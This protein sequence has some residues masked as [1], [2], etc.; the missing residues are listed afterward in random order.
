M[1]D[2]NA[3]MTFLLEGS[4]LY[5]G[6][7]DQSSS[8]VIKRYLA[9]RIIVNAMSFEDLVGKRLDTKMR[10]IR[11]VILA[12]KQESDFFEGHKAADHI[13]NQTITSLMNFMEAQIS[14]IDA[15]YLLAENIDETSKGMLATL[16]PQ[17]F[18]LYQKDFLA[19]FRIINNYLCFT[20]QS[21]HEV[22]KNDLAG[23]FYRYHSSKSL[24]DLSEYLFNNAKTEDNLNGLYR[25]TKLDMLMHAQNMADCIIKDNRNNHSID[26]LLEVMTNEKIGD[27]SP[28]ASLASDQNFQILYQKVRN[29]RNKLIGHMDKSQALSSLLQ[30]LDDLP[31]DVPSSL[32]NIV[33]KAV[34][35]AARSHIAVW[36]RYCTGNQVLRD[37]NIVSI[38]GLKLQ[39]Y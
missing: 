17:V 22:S 39:P 11:N 13:T 6:M 24:Y 38:P 25:H 23:V 3:K 32:V 20:G 34:F 4:R 16:V 12:H 30:L 15:Q 9:F 35:L 7:I 8:D 37:K 26:G 33:D 36:G 18:D 19:G 2:E 10:E 31:D 21:I 28:L 29:L 5:Q 1:A 14:T 27:A